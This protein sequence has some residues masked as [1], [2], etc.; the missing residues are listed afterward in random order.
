M[1]P[2]PLRRLPP[3]RQSG[4]FPDSSYDHCE[5]RCPFPSSTSLR[6]VRRPEGFQPLRNG[7]VLTQIVA[8]RI[9]LDIQNRG[10]RPGVDAAD[11]EGATCAA[12]QPRCAD[13]ERVRAARGTRR[14]QPHLR[15]PGATLWRVSAR[16]PR[17]AGPV[18]PDDDEEVAVLLDTG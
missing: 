10:A 12:E 3:A 14:E 17:P 16:L 2:P 9:A 1:G 5:Q 13:A 11:P 6:V 15:Q 4:R 18:E 7:C 8:W